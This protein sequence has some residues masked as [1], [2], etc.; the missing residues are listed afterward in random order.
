ML[1]RSYSHTARHVFRSHSRTSV[2]RL[3]RSVTRFAQNPR[4]SDSS[5]I[6]SCTRSFQSSS[7][8]PNLLTPNE[9]ST[10]V[11]ASTPIS[12]E[13]YHDRADTY[14]DSLVSQLE[15]LQEE[16][17]D[18]D[19]EYSVCFS[20]PILLS[21]ILKIMPNHLSLSPKSHDSFTNRAMNC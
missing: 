15:Q 3:S 5:H 10:H 6:H 20:L 7:S 21:L 9:P 19:C 4:S 11:S 17:E 16:R 8:Q 2:K 18:V 12:T 1:S 14:I 13:K